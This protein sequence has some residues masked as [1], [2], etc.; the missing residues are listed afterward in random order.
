VCGLKEVKAV[1]KLLMT[2]AFPV[3]ESTRKILFRRSRWL[4][5]RQASLCTR[6]RD[7]L[8]LFAVE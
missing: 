3:D 2:G 7:P 5:A 1:E 6:F 8:R 4:K